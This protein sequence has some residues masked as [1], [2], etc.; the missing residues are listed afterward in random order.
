MKRG[1]EIF[2]QFRC[3]FAQIFMVDIFKG[4]QYNICGNRKSASP[5][6]WCN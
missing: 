1:I 5:D 4:F 3:L 2:Y 6:K